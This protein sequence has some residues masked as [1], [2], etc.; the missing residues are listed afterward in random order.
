MQR[1]ELRVLALQ[2]HDALQQFSLAFGVTHT[3]APASRV[4]DDVVQVSFG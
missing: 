4:E 1:R 2:F 3:I